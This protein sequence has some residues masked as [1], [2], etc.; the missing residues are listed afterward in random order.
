[1]AISLRLEDHVQSKIAA[2]AKARGISK[3]ALIRQCLDD[4][5][6]SEAETPTAWELGKDLFG[7]WHSGR[8]DLSARI[9]EIAGERIHARRAKKRRR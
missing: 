9:K 3:S 2:L 6:K 8:G 4:F 5:L 1:M 7:C